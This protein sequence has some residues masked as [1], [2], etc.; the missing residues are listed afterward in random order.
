MQSNRR[1]F[2]PILILVV[3]GVVA[4]GLFA[5]LKGVE[6]GPSRGSRDGLSGSP[7]QRPG[8]DCK[9]EFTKFGASP[10]RIEDIDYLVPMGRMSGEHVT[11]TDHQYFHPP[12]WSTEPTPRDVIAPGDGFITEIER[13]NFQ[14]YEGGRTATDYNVTIEYSCTV[15]SGFI[16]VTEFSERVNELAGD[17]KAGTSKQLR[18][19]IIEGEAIGTIRGFANSSIYQLDF[20]VFDTSTTLPGLLT[21]SF[22]ESEWWKIYIVDPL[23]Y[24][25]ES[26][27]SQL[28]TKNLRSVAPLGGKIDYDIDGKLVGNWFEEGYVGY[29][30][31]KPRYWEQ[32][33]TFAY[34]HIDPTQVRISI[35]K[36]DP[37]PK[38]FG[39]VGNAPDPATVGVEERVKYELTGYEYVD[40]SGRSWDRQSYATGLRAESGDNVQGVIL[41]QLLENRKLKVE[42]FPGK[43]ADQVSGFT[44]AAEI[45]VR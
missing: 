41:V 2:A 34:D 8:K 42:V 36:Y 30:A 40:E 4:F 35:G 19:P 38:Q 21:P 39:I 44:S 20:L 31:S 9:K 16:H 5:I 1:G 43:S 6:F 11:P 26:V 10:L 24:F 22:Y 3:V 12:A 15:S 29:T 7:R 18:I 37:R 23:D 17:I 28:L 45:Y 27:R 25:S 32:E 13:L 33:L 14:A